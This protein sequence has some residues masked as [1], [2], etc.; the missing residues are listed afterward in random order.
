[1]SDNANEPLLRMEKITK[2]FPGTLALNNV[3]F[4]LR[5]GE[6]HILLGENG[7]GKSTLMKILSGAYSRDGGRIFIEGREVGFDNPQDSQKAGVSII[8]QELAQVPQLSATENIFLGREI[9]VGPRIDWKAMHSRARELLD[10]IDADFSEKTEVRKLSIAHRQMVE[11]AKALSLNAKIIVMDEPTSS[12]TP[13]E[14]EKLFRIIANLRAQGKG[15]VFISHHLDEIKEIGDRGT[16]LRDGTFISTF[17]VADH[18]IESII[19]MMVGRSLDGKY[20]K[21]RAA[22]GD[23]IL[24][25]EGLT[26]RGTVN[27]VSFSL[28]RGEVLGLA[29]LVGAGRTELCRLIFG[30]DEKDAGRIFIN[31]REANISSPET[32]IRNKIGFLTENRKEEGL[33][34]HQS[35]INN[36]SMPI[37]RSLVRN[38]FRFLNIIDHSR[39]EALAEEYFKKLNIRAPS[40][41]K[42]SG[43]LS[44]GNQQKVVFAKWIASNSDIL[45]IDEPTR[46]IDVG[47]KAEIYALINNLAANGVGIIMVSSELPE[48]LGMSDRILVMCAG[49]V[50]GELTDP[51]TFTQEEVMRYAIK[52]A[53]RERE[54]A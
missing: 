25:V 27:N 10:R 54:T 44:G 51:A 49:S 39:D 9:T 35:I 6:V 53:P 45:I 41:R 29:G 17:D 26:R 8:Y 1:M 31:G 40:I 14:V 46:G 28:R 11:I 4:S 34:L 43:E 52:F 12:L 48:V 50:T 24:R 32:A 13:H 3:D 5:A 23:E 33:V 18:S 7:A 42:R 16:V 2:R 20:P 47:A 37:L 36:I 15:I 38:N 22:I 21:V 30:A 19:E